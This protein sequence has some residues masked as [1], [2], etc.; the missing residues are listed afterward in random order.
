MARNKN[1]I[2]EK[3]KS[4]IVKKHNRVIKRGVVISLIAIMLYCLYLLINA[5]YILVL[6]DIIRVINTEV[7][8]I[9][10]IIFFSII[11]GWVAI[12]WLLLVFNVMDNKKLRRYLWINITLLFMVL[13]LAIGLFVVSSTL[14]PPKLDLVLRN[15]DNIGQVLGNISCKDAS[16]KL[17]LDNMVMCK[18]YP[19]LNNLS[20]IVSFR[21]DNGSEINYDFSNLSFM[22]PPSTNYISFGMH[23]ID[24]YN[25]TLK[26][27]VGY[28]FTFYTK[29]EANKRSGEYIT[30]IVFIF[31]VLFAI[32]AMMNSFKNLSKK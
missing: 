31:G 22:P 11:I 18:I 14:G 3:K 29:E 20:A 4:E 21:I 10:I 15:A 27:V 32:P 17:L 19:E 28:P 8:T 9:S 6:S 26:L 1:R 5:L 30:Y 12:N 13:A 2:K 24:Q 16:G 25:K 23:G 7:L